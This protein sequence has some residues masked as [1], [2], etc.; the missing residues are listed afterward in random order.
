MFETGWAAAK[1]FH[2]ASARLLGKTS[3]SILGDVVQAFTLT[4][5]VTGISKIASSVSH[6]SGIP[7]QVNIFPEE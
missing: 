5:R 3:W 6:L 7:G 4:G 1:G 2:H